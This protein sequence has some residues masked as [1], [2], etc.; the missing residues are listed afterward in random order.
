MRIQSPSL[1]ELH[2]FLAVA[3]WGSFRRAALELC[4]TQ[5]AVS[6]AVARLEQRLACSLFER[7]AVGVRC[8]PR[9]LALQREVQAP[10][11]ALEQAFAHVGRSRSR[12]RPVVGIAVVPTLGTRWL[13][14]RLAAFRAKHPD[15]EVRMQQFHY[16]EDYSRDDVELWIDIKRQP[17]RWPRGV[18]S[19]Y[20][21]GREIMPVCAPARA[22][23]LRT[24]RDLL[25]APLLHHTNFP[26]NWALWLQAA[27]LDAPALKLGPGFDLGNN[28][29]VAASADM[30]V[31]VIQPCLIERELAR[32]ELVIPFGPLVSTGRGYHLCHKASPTLTS[33]AQHVSDW[34]QHEA[35]ET[36]VPT[37]G[38]PSLKP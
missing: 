14:P 10:L 8:T 27:G 31:A 11:A 20:L 21:L 22:A 36:A 15:I 29:I 34:L 5:A 23:R 7:S 33:S 2:A 12:E 37:P 13:V 18:R 19:R 26:N 4:V 35:R 32:G 16:D 6:R 30:G 1:V 28:L 24:P 3:Q 25:R 9:G 17:G 38:R